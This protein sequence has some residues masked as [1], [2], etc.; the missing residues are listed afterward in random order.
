MPR[1]GAPTVVDVQ[2]EGHRSARSWA[3]LAKPLLLIAVGVV[4]GIL[5]LP[6]DQADSI[7]I[8]AVP[9]AP[10][11]PA[12]ELRTT[13]PGTWKAVDGG[14]LSPRRNPIAVWAEDQA[15]IWGGVAATGAGLNDGAA[16]DPATD[17]WTTIPPAPVRART[18]AA[19]V[20]TGDEVLV[21]GGKDAEGVLGDGAA[22]DPGT[23]T[24]R[25]L[26]AAPLTPR[27]GAHGVWVD[28]VFVVWGGRSTDGTPLGDG[29]RY[30]PATDRWRP[31]P[32][33]PLAQRGG[34]RDVSVVADT[35]GLLV[36]SASPDSAV[37]AHY[38]VQ[39]DRWRLQRSPPLRPG[40]RPAFATLGGGVVTWGTDA[41]LD[42][43][44]AQR[45]TTYPDWWSDLPRPPVA[46][47][48]GRRLVGDGMVAVSWWSGGHALVLDL[49][50]KTWTEVAV[51]DAGASG[52]DV[53]VQLWAGDR[54]LLW[55]PGLP[56]GARNRGTTWIPPTRWERVAAG[57][58]PTGNG[59][60]AVWSGWLT[61]GQQLLVWGGERGEVIEAGAAYHPDLGLWE[62]MPAAPI[63]GR[64]RHA[65]AWTGDRM[66]VVGGYDQSPVD[67]SGPPTGPLTPPGPA[68]RDGAAYDPVTRTWARIADA[69]IPVVTEAAAYSGR[70]LYA[71]A[72]RGG[73][74]VVA[75]YD[76]GA[77][78]WERLPRPPISPGR[79]PPVLM[80][81]GTR[82]WMFGGDANAPGRGATWDSRRRRWERMP[83]LEGMWGPFAVTWAD[84]RMVVI[85]QQGR[86]ASLG[87]A[88]IDGWLPHGD[89]PVHGD[90]VTL[91][92]AVGGLTAFSPVDGHMAV[93]DP[94]GLGWTTVE[95][96][97]VGGRWADLVWNGRH[98][99]AL[100]GGETA[101]MRP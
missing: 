77:D 67:P 74:T 19:V 17:E 2:W 61:E 42:L 87:R 88:W 39:R 90:G 55:H 89:A 13:G 52:G 51:P 96:P 83:P 22:Y 33:G 62:T 56:P 31:L 38:D 101:M 41:R 40:S 47:A 72:Q 63:S 85:D 29:A 93:L 16:Y 4:A 68:R 21:W 34:D 60:S 64:H 59:T 3:R 71:A 98:L 58:A 7:G 48:A 8:D 57:P 73:R 69:P 14:P 94:R 80:W 36:W 45:Q 66:L 54:Y 95:A 82:L 5:A 92:W 99:F 78:R 27:A 15:I 75:E 81:S 79:T 76:P 46:P 49:L 70:R 9:P 43:P 24:W 1:A 91:E 32:E 84:R 10:P 28:E 11:A 86:T 23:R 35:G 20:W 26:P 53:P 44:R 30:D 18:S 65:A 12:A 50:A 37:T 25:Q 100:A 6:S 97:P